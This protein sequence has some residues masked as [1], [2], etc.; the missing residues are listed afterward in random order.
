MHME[1]E[2]GELVFRHVYSEIQFITDEGQMLSVCMTQGGFE[3]CL[4]NEKRKYGPR[5][6]KIENG[7]IFDDE[8]NTGE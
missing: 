8:T 6:V 2:N 4:S 1:I 5:R 7:K 3:I